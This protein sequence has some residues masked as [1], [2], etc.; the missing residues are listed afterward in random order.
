MKNM[1]KMFMILMLSVLLVGCAY[2][3]NNSTVDINGVEFEIPDKYHGGEMKNG[4]Y[5]LNNI[6]SIRCIDNDVANAIGLWATESDYDNNLT[7]GNHPVRHDC[8]YNQYV[9]G[10][11]SH[12]YFISGKSAYEISWVGSEID[13]DIE[14]LIKNTPDSEIGADDFYSALDDSIEMYKQQRIDKLNRD[15]EYNYLEAKFQSQ[16]PQH[17]LSDDIRFKEILLTHYLNG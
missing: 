10:N 15:A 13:A 16:Y 3:Q 8:Q 5:Q 17:D 6:F 9:K 4:K 12:A 2:A 14:E 1:K 11:N 7:I